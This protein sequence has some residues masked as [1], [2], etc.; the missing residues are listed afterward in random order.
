M[1]TIVIYFNSMA[2]AGG[3]ERVISNLANNW[4]LKYKIIILTKDDS[5][6]FY[7]LDKNIQR[8]SLKVLSEM[9]MHNRS[10]RIFSTLTGLISAK[11]KL[12]KFFSKYSCDYIYIATPLNALE[13]YLASPKLLKKSVIAEHASYFGYN[14]IYQIIKKIIY[15]KAKIISTP[16][17]MDQKKYDDLGYNS[18]YIPHT[19]TFK[20]KENYSK[21]NVALSVGRLTADKRQLEL[22]ENWKQFKS[23]D[24]NSWKL[25]LVGNGELKEKLEDFIDE[26]NLKSSV[27]ILDPTTKLGDIYEQSSL[28]LFT[29]RYEG[30]GMVL[31]EAMSFGLPCIAYDIPSG[32]R[33]IIKSGVNGFL[34]SDDDNDQYV[35]KM[36]ELTE[37]KNLLLSMKQGAFNTAYN[38]NNEKILKR[39]D[40]EI[41]I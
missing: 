41:F 6:S 37:N 13:I 21:Q 8:V 30:F 10:Q 23:V 27:K 15:P 16:T 3:I 4:S 7:Y 18:V 38:W 31:L 2:P 40:D 11:L 19:S 17:T 5:K 33:D 39:W 35:K 28:F 9:N 25:I 26:N 12:K 22:L 34:I 29:S 32:P 14:K 36:I 1:K 20:A 24:K